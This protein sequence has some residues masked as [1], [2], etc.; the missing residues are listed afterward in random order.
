MEI[1]TLHGW[2]AI[3]SK[4][5]TAR[6]SRSAVSAGSSRAASRQT[7]GA[8]AGHVQ[9]GVRVSRGPSQGLDGLG[10]REDEQFDVASDG[11]ALHIIHHGQG[12]GAGPHDQTPAFPGDLLVHRERR[13]TE[14][15]AELLGRLLL[16]LAN[17][18]A[19]DHDIMVID[20]TVNSDR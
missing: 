14:L 17:L 10:C 8:S 13:V 15:V 3:K 9:D 1:G 19:V 18:S 20:D 5:T 11:F 16:P 7:A 12:T 4:T 2:L 6:G